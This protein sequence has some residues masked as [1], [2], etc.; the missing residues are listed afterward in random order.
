[1]YRC[2]TDLPS[3]SPLLGIKP[4]I[5]CYAKCLT[6]GLLPLA[7]TLASSAIFDVFLGDTKLE[8]LLH[9]HSYTAHPIGC[10]VA[11]ESLQEYERIHRDAGA[12]SWS[13]WNQRKVEHLSGLPA[14]ER[15]NVMGTVLVVELCDSQ[16]GTGLALTAGYLSM[17]AAKFTKMLKD[18]YGIFARPLGNVIYFLAGQNSNP[19]DL[20]RVLDGIEDALQRL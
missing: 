14:V 18:D 7:A 16:K 3:V 6:G 5:A 10:S 19:A 11:L 1:M 8:A 15:I 9:G 2:G 13:A 12:K 17:G 20:D 4:D